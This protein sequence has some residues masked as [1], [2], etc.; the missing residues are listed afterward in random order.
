MLKKVNAALLGLLLSLSLWAQPLAAQTLPLPG[1]PGPS[2]G[3]FTTN[4][5][6][7][8]KGVIAGS[9]VG[10]GSALSVSQSSGQS[11]CTQLGTV[12]M[13][14]VIGTSAGTGY[15]CLPAAIPGFYKVIQNT[16][17]QSISIYGGGSASS[18][19]V[20]GTQD[21]I[22]GTV[23][24][25]AYTGLGSHQQ[26]ICI[27]GVGGAWTCT[28]GTNGAGA[29]TTLSASSTV[30][31]AGFTARFASPGPIGN[32]APSTG[33]FTTLSATGAVTFSGLLSFT[34]MGLPTIASGACGATT[35]GAV[36]AGSTDQSGNITIGSAST[37]TCTVSFST[38]LATAPLACVIQPANS[39]AAAVGTTAAY[40]S[41]ITTA[42]FVITGTLANANYAYHCI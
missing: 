28:G 41:A 22:N 30:S 18:Q 17:A 42:H 23:G 39:A 40:I 27:V 37:A 15:V 21:T 1:T 6:T 24:S 33:A 9:T 34:G 8:T 32:T 26:V 10:V 19:F 4:L 2:L 35:N 29:F 5:Y 7:L 16:T 13:V 25:T 3:D 12:N 31:G 11:N 14:H 38:T 36:V 20:P